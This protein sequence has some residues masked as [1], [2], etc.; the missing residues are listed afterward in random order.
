MVR[1]LRM[2]RKPQDKGLMCSPTRLIFH[3]T[4]ALSV[5]SSGYRKGTLNLEVA[6]VWSRWKTILSYIGRGDVNMT[7]RNEAITQ[8]VQSLNG[9]LTALSHFLAKSAEKALPFFKTLKGCI[10]R[11][12][13][14]WNQEAERAFQELKLHLQSLP[15]LVVPTPGET[16][17]LYLVV[18]HEI[19][20]S[21]LMAERKNVQRPIYFISK[22][23]HGPKVNYPLHEKLA[24]V[25][26]HTARR[27][28]RYFRAHTICVLIGQPI[29]QI[30]LKQENSGRLAKWDIELGEHDIIYKP[31]SA[32]KGQTLYIDGASGSDGSREGL[33]LTDPDGNEITY[34]LWFDFPTS[35][36]EAEYATLIAGLELA[37]RL[38]VCHLQDFTGSLLEGFESFLITQVS[39]S[40]NKRVDALSKLASSYFAHPT[41]NVLVEVIPYKSIEAHATNTVEDDRETYMTPIIEYLQDGRLPEDPNLARKIKIKAPQYFMKQGNLYRKGYSALW[42]QCVGP[43]QAHY[44]LQEAHF[45][46]C[47]AHAR[48]RTIA[49][50][51][52][53]LEFIGPQCTMMQPRWSTNATTSKNTLLSHD[54]HNVT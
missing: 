11:K 2:K 54:N 34:T 30:L 44:V 50:K 36:N 33:I 6:S 8:E 25:L 17:T 28:R 23:L 7:E 18:S 37:L 14:R 40:K 10:D 35:N 15:A 46:S 26:V 47:G 41:K 22:A 24:L 29:H 49:Q 31:R 19:I 9:K 52:A 48:A 39:R 45:G 13:F 32:V 5:T 4:W 27:L 21:V 38:E 53:R 51:A 1:K 16:L 20:S 12:D 42:L 3:Q 43:N